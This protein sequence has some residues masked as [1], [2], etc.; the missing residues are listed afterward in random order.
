MLM[1]VFCEKEYE[2]ALVRSYWRMLRYLRRAMPREAEDL[3]NDVFLAAWNARRGFRGDATVDTLV[4]RIC[5]RTVA[6]RRRQLRRHFAD[7]GIATGFD[8]GLLAKVDASVD[9]SQG[10]I[11]LEST[12]ATALSKLEPGLAQIV[13]LFYVEGRTQREIA[14]FLELAPGTV[15]SRLLRAKGCLRR[16]GLEGT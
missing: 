5:V 11:D 4:F 3:A 16:L 13:T 8:F 6:R 12:V 9:E 7:L 1:A 15:A 2:L 10:S 14:D